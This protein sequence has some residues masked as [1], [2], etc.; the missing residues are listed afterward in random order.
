MDNLFKALLIII[1]GGFL[2]LYYNNSDNNRFQ[3][4]PQAGIALLDTKTGKIYDYGNPLVIYDL[5]NATT[6]TIKVI[7]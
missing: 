4:I 5:P 7:E 2:Y 3:H 1:L 6:K